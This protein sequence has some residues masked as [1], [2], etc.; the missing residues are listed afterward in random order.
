MKFWLAPAVGIALM[1]ATVLAVPPGAEADPYDDGWD[2]F[3]RRDYPGA[4]AIWRPLAEGGDARAQEILGEMYQMAYGVPQDDDAAVE[5]YRRAA[6]QDYPPAE[7][8]LGAMYQSGMGVAQN[9]VEAVIWL[10][11]AAEQGLGQSQIDLARILRDGD[12]VPRDLVHAYLWFE[13]A[14][15]QGILGAAEGR[16]EAAERMTPAEIES[17]RRLAADWKPRPSS[18]PIQ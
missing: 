16:D 11:R 9:T 12:G 5:W 17:A 18:L 15:R 6:E 7:H 3:H 13:V 2:A 10:R 8:R 1:S 4:V 14:A